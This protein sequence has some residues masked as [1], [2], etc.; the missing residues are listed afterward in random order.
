MSKGLSHWNILPG[1]FLGAV[2][3]TLGDSFTTSDSI[4]YNDVVSKLSSDRVFVL[5]YYIVVEGGTFTLGSCTG[6]GFWTGG[7]GA[8]GGA[9]Q[10]LRNSA[11]CSKLLRVVSPVEKLVVVNG[12]GF[13]RSK[14]IS[15][16]AW[17]R[18][19][20]NL[21][22]GNL[23]C[24]GKKVTVFVSIVVLV[25]GIKTWLI[26]SSSCKDHDNILQ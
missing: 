13:V 20:I 21:T 22:A 25:A 7:S 10:Q 23:T 8:S 3:F 6:G 4:T 9:V 12:G 16:S 26:G 1:N 15:I 19:Y 2:A 17:W 18:K 11:I 24:V 14:M 5:V